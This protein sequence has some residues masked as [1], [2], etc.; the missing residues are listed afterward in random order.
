[1]TDS[2]RRLAPVVM[3]GGSGA[4]RV[5]VLGKCRRR[6]S[7]WL[8]RPW[9]DRRREKRVDVNRWR[10][11]AAAALVAATA[12]T[13]LVAVGS[14]AYAN[15]NALW[16]GKIGETHGTFGANAAIRVWGDL[17]FKNSGCPEDGVPDFVYPTSDV[18][19]VVPGTAMGHLVDV[20]GGKPNTVVQYGSVFDDEIIGITTPA[21]RLPAGEFDVVFD[22]CQ[23]GVFQPEDDAVFSRAIKV[24]I[25]AELPPPDAA[26]TSLKAAAYQ[27]YESWKN[28]QRI[29]NGV[30]KLVQKALKNGC[31]AG[32]PTACALKYG[33]YFNPIQEQFNGLLLNQGQHYLGIYEDPPNPDFDQPVVP[34]KAGASSDAIAGEG[35]LVEA[36]LRS[37]EAYKGAQ[38]A[39]SGEWA[40]VHAREVRDLHHALA[41]QLAATSRQLGDLKARYAD[42]NA[43]DGLAFGHQFLSRIRQQGFTPDERRTLRHNGMTPPQITAL[44]VDIRNAYVPAY[45]P[46]N[47]RE[48][49]DA[50][51]A[52]HGKTVAAVNAGR[53]AWSAIVDA[54]AGDPR[55]PDTRPVGNAGGP[56]TSNEGASVTLDA[57][58]S[59]GTKPLAYAW[60]LDGDRDFDDA[61]G[62]KPAVVFDEP[63]TALVGLRVTDS[64]GREA[65][66][67]TSATVQRKGAD[68]QLPGAT[69]DT[70]QRMVETGEAAEFKVTATDDGGTPAVTWTVDGKAAGDGRS[71]SWTAPGTPG[72]HEVVATA[73]DEDGHTATRGWDVLV[74]KADGDGDGWTLTTDCN[75]TD[76][77]VHPGQIEFLGNG[78]DDDCDAGSPDAPP[79]GLTGDM[80]GWG[81]NTQG[82][83]GNGKIGTNYTK[84]TKSVL[85]ANVVQVEMGSATGYAVLADSTVRAWGYQHAGE[86]GDGT[87]NARLQP[88]QPLGPGGQGLLSGVRQLSATSDH[89]A[90]VRTDGKVLTWGRNAAGNL[91]NGA[92]SGNRSFPD[93]VLADAQGNHLTGVRDV[94]TGVSSDYALMEDGTVMAWGRVNC[95][96]S[97][98]LEDTLYPARI[99]DLTDVRQIAVS[100]AIVLF[101]KKDGT[102]LSCGGTDVQ[103]GRKWNQSDPATSP[104]LPRPVD[105]L[106][107]AS[108]VVDITIS[109]DQAV[110]LKENGAVWMWGEN[111]NAGLAP[112]LGDRKGTLLVPTQAPMP[113]GPPIVGIDN[114]DSPTTLAIRADGSMIVWGGN[115]FGAAGTG[116][117]GFVLAPAVVPI[118]G[119]AVLQ[120]SASGWNGLALTRPKADP[121]LELPASWVNATVDDATL[122]EANGG[123]FTVKLDQALSDDVALN[124]ALQPGTAGEDDVTLGTGTVV[125]PAGQMQASIPV[126]V[127]DDAIDEDDE[128]ITLALT[129]ARLGL[130]I[131]RA[132][133][134]GTIA[135]NDEPPVVTVQHASVVE[136]GTSLTDT[137]V[138]FR[139]SKPSGKE[140]VAAYATADGTAK[141]GDDYVASAA[142][143]RFA[144]G[145]AEDVVHLAVNGDAIQ[146]PDETFTVSVGE[147][148]NGTAGES[149]TVTVKDDEVLT[150]SVAAPIITEG[151]TG[152]FV[153]TVDPAPLPGTTVSVPWTLV[154]PEPKAGS[155]DKPGDIVAAGG[156]LRLTAQQPVGVVTATTVDDT[157]VEPPEPFL[158]KLGDLTASDGRT[159]H[160]GESAA[161][162]ITDNDKANQPP[163]V[164]AGDSVTA[165]EGS[166]VALAGS[167]SDD[168]AGVTSSWAVDGPCTVTGE[169]VQATVTCRDEGTFVATLTATDVAGAAASDSTTVTVTNASPVLGAVSVDA[170]GARIEFTDAGVD[171]QHTCTVQWGDETTPG[172]LA[173]A[174]S[175]CY[176]PHQY[177]PGT[178][179]ATVTVSDDDGGSASVTRTVTV[180][181][182]A[183]P[184]RG[185]LPPVDNPPAVN[186]VNAGRAIPIK[187]GLGGYRGMDILAPGSPASG[188]VSCGGGEPN[189][190]EEADAANGSSVSYD[191]NGDHYTYVWKTD[192]TWAGQCRRLIVT[193][194][195]GTQHW[196]EFRFR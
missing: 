62:D 10:R 3:A 196:A 175:P 140:V 115:T 138:T 193:L 6:L 185:F 46:A 65:Y 127:A 58:A 176:L 116:T 38:H 81:S 74:H 133:A 182:P 55:V 150:V 147:V 153:V 50:Q 126:E 97:G 33:N 103:L 16:V 66:G 169:G 111:T 181:A 41:G 20:T 34:G 173:G 8:G 23:D 154:E 143:I 43:K 87:T 40:L 69:P 106:G 162:W 151:E 132:Q 118:D 145:E 113:A 93:Y 91:G 188:P 11:A 39:G 192:K 12:V 42:E 26:L 109:G 122:S 102:V 163:V 141:A 75:D 73:T 155:G 83:I 180:Q 60:D 164:D 165:V 37:V 161:A 22:T 167:V 28:T 125:V 107:R 47:V 67:W 184:F 190:L 114:G 129:G 77:A 59:T 82:Q 136:G 44:E 36:L 79:G 76:A 92:S 117:S 110:V 53:T 19:I 148:T 25:P 137:P 105:T 157:E 89:V 70:V 32:N 9:P 108:K 191:A 135:D 86:I 13:G 131:T 27:E 101:L 186:V 112:I 149:G 48:V 54:L 104:W 100:P 7:P 35:A 177:R 52:T 94:Q 156:T 179:T 29:M 80:Y 139:L 90:A 121:D 14:P 123:A 119:Q 84:P 146:E 144:P 63:G 124:W 68:P 51:V 30:W 56:Y 78:V 120:V 95:D 134:T 171:D 24:E 99:P 159:V 172:V 61:T 71:L 166:A 189:S 174:L 168:A 183:W 170:A 178:F 4:S 49:L 98:A 194:A 142:M 18:Y 160:R 128:T 152:D 5:Q 2:Y 130:T 17:A 88:V 195:D 15:S 96:G 31:K 1:M 57:S 85:P 21:G 158:L 187:F 45:T 72:A 64:A